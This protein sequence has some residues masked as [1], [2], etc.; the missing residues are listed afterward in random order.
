MQIYQTLFKEHNKIIDSFYWTKE[1]FRAEKDIL[2]MRMSVMLL[3]KE[4]LSGL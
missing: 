4:K 3:L 2:N 1:E